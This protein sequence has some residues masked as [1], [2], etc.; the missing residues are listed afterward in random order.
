MKTRR[1]TLRCFAVLAILALC[2]SLMGPFTQDAEACL[3][4][5]AACAIRDG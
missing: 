4:A 5:D 2:V 3:A 1:N